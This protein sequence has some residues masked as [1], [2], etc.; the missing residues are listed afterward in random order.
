MTTTRHKWLL[1]EPR[2]K[3]IGGKPSS[4]IFQRSSVLS[5]LHK[6]K[7][8]PTEARFITPRPHSHSHHR[9]HKHSLLTS[10][11]FPKLQ[12]TTVSQ[13]THGRRPR[14]C[15]RLQPWWTLDPVLLVY[16]RSKRPSERKESGAHEPPC[17]ACAQSLLTIRHAHAP[18]GLHA[19]RP[20]SSSCALIRP[21]LIFFLTATPLVINT[22]VLCVVFS[23]APFFFFRGPRWTSAHQRPPAH[24]EGWMDGKWSGNSFLLGSS[25]LVNHGG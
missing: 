3:P 24:L 19:R 7:K 9:F 23:W 11:L 20:S 17:P 12:E 16:K 21:F 6:R 4:L 13:R 14:E 1:C 8:S 25:S 2:L 10:L 18:N 22:S 5:L 15:S